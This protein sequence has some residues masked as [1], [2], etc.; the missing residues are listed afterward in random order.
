MFPNNITFESHIKV[1]TKKG[2]NYQIKKLWIFQQILLVS[3]L[4]NY[5][6]RCGIMHIDI[7]CKRLQTIPGPL[8]LKKSHSDYMMKNL[9]AVQ[10]KCRLKM[11]IWRSFSKFFLEMQKM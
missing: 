2:N 4:R 9:K 7:K 8:S 1:M 6:G 3:S 5:R 10:Y 11:P